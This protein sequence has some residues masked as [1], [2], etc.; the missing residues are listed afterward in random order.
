MGKRF[1]SFCNT[2]KKKR[3]KEKGRGNEIKEIMMAKEI[4]D[5]GRN[6]TEMDLEKYTEMV[7]K[8]DQDTIREM[9]KIQ[10]EL[11]IA[12]AGDLLK[13]SHSVHS[14]GMKMILTKNLL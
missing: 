1:I 5:T 2:L 13:S 12:T 3:E 9:N 10:K 6:E 14:L 11:K 8:L 7:L 4:I